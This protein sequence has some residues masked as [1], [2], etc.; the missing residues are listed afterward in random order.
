VRFES[1]YTL[2]FFPELYI[3]INFQSKPFRDFFLVAF[4]LIGI[5]CIF[6]LSFGLIKPESSSQ[7]LSLRNFECSYRRFNVISK[8]RLLLIRVC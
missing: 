2:K 4:A 1:S 6:D 3:Q 7:I 5:F 8:Y